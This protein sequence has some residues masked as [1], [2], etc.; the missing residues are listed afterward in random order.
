MYAS[1]SFPEPFS[2]LHLHLAHSHVLAQE[3]PQP[4]SS[5]LHCAC[6]QQVAAHALTGDTLWCGLW[7]F[8]TLA[9]FVVTLRKNGCLQVG[10]HEGCV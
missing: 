9:F 3:A 8:F 10:P 6:P 1:G 4:M 2:A 7:G 5:H